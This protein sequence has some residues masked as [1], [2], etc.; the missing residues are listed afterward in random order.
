MRP[1]PV[2]DGPRQGQEVRLEVVKRMCPNWA[3]GL[4]RHIAV[5]DL[6]RRLYSH[7]RVANRFQ[8]EQTGSDC[9][10]HGVRLVM[11]QTQDHVSALDQGSRHRAFFRLIPICEFQCDTSTLAE[12]PNAH[13]LKQWPQL[14]NRLAKRR[15]EFAVEEPRIPLAVLN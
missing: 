10:P 11:K 4:R 7:L 13:L 14:R 5:C 3:C 1:A 2:A 8:I 6:D 15:V 9:F 12:S